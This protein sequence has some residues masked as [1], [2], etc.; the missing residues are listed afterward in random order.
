MGIGRREFLGVVGATLAAVVNPTAAVAVVENRYINRRLGIAFQKPDDWVFSDV[1]QMGE[2]RAG[3][4]LAIDDL[5]L[6][7]EIIEAEKLP[8]LTVSKEKLSANAENFTPGVTIYLDRLASDEETVDD[9]LSPVQFLELDILSC[10]FMLKAFR[11]TASP[12]KCRVSECD[13]ALSTANFTF[14]HQ[15]LK[16]TPVRMRTLVIDQGTALYTLRMFDAPDI[17]DEMCF[18]FEPFIESVKMV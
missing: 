12:E 10:A 14:E 15:N 4:V 6:A 9:E 16:P 1:K 3:Q 7:K 5:E 17:G 13:A 18:D 2:V 11:V 8:I